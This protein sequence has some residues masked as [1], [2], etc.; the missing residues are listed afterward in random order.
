MGSGAE[1]SKIDL[2]P[3]PKDLHHSVYGKCNREMFIFKFIE[4]LDNC[5]TV[6][7]GFP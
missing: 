1:L 6:S 2:D 3:Q 7:T 5:P 4:W